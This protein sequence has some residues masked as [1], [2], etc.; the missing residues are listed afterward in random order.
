MPKNMARI[1]NGIVINIEWHADSSMETE[2]LRDINSLHVGIGDVYDG[3]SFYHNGEKLLTPLEESN[4]KNTKL[5]TALKIITGESMSTSVIEQCYAIR[6]TMDEVGAILTPEQA[7]QY[8]YLYRSWNST[9]DASAVMTLAL[10]EDDNPSTAYYYVGARRRY[11]DVVYECIK[12]H[13]A[14]V[15]VTPNLAADKWNALSMSE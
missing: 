5:T 15:G 14:E 11:N 10:D 4:D 13:Y 12:E 9:P 7:A 8:P 2:T 1:K 6:T 3:S